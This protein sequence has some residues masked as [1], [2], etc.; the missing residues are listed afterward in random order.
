MKKEKKNNYKNVK[1]R[2]Y[3]QF[4]NKKEVGKKEKQL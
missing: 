1:K 4:E 2:K 3:K